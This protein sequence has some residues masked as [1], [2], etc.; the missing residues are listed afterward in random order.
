MTA[1]SDFLHVVCPHCHATN[2]VLRGRLESSPRCGSCKESLL[3]VYPIELN[4]A[5]F[6]R[7]LSSDDLPLVVDFWAAWCAPCRMMAPAFTQAA[8][9]LKLKARL[10]KLDTEAET[11]IAARYGIR[12]IPTL[13]A[14]HRGRELARQSGALD[15]QNLLAWIKAH[16]RNM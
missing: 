6:D 15:L 13:I 1:M 7:H 4:T 11:A 8:A 16:V 5:G 12:S 10:A 3:P 9:Q 2:R 14:F